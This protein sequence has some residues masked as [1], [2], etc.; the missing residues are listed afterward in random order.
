MTA[1]VLD[2]ELVAQLRQGAGNDWARKAKAVLVGDAL[3][4]VKERMLSLPVEGLFP[5]GVDI[6]ERIARLA[7][8]SV[9]AED[10]LDEG[11]VCV[12]VGVYVYFLAFSERIGAADFDAVFS[13]AWRVY[14]ASVADWMAGGVEVV[15]GALI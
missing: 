14:F 4:P 12:A 11:C 13:S 2:S 6:P 7:F 10:A 3:A 1:I 9:G 8:Q 5:S 15:E